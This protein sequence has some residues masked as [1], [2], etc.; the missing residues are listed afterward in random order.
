VESTKIPELPPGHNLAINHAWIWGRA[1]MAQATR[2]REG[3]GI[4]EAHQLLVAL[5]QVE[6]ATEM[7]QSGS[8]KKHEAQQILNS[9]VRQFK[10]DLPA[11]VDARDI[12]EHFDKYAIG[13]GKL[14]SKD[15]DADPS[16]TDFD[17]AKRYE[18]RIDGPS[19]EESIIRVNTIS[20][21]VN[22][23]VDAVDLLF[24]RMFKAA[25]VEDGD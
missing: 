20:I 10:A 2:V 24:R 25:Q 18:V 9:A 1:A 22:K 15:R 7:A 17:L 3:G 6:R 5:R 21:E 13:K 14:Q 19:W 12:I 23:V 4:S 11:L 16:L 8:L